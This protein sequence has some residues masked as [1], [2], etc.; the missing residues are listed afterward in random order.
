LGIRLVLRAEVVAE[1]RREYVSGRAAGCNRRGAGERD[2]R[3]AQWTSGAVV[4]K[5]MSKTKM[6]KAKM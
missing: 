2:Q 3:R 1:T 6:L 5:W 4:K